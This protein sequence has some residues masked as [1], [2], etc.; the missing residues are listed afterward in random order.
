M[1]KTRVIKMTASA[2]L[3]ID[4]GIQYNVVGSTVCIHDVSV[5]ALPDRA[6]ALWYLYQFIKKKFVLLDDWDV[7]KGKL[8]KNK[9]I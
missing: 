4:T 5:F 1:I 2:Y 6:D 7:L 3:N 8:D 9:Y